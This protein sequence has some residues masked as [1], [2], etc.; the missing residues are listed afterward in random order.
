MALLVVRTGVVSQV[1][2]FG[3]RCR[4]TSRTTSRGYR[5]LP[6][7]SVRVQGME[8]MP[9]SQKIEGLLFDMGGV[10]F[11]IDFN[12]ALRTWKQWTPLPLEELQSRFKMDEPY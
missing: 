9:G 4:I 11:N 8:T 12:L 5:A 2:V 6:L 3:R 7:M 1:R 10:L